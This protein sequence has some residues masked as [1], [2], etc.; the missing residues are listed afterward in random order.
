[1]MYILKNVICPIWK[2]KQKQCIGVLLLLFLFGL[3]HIDSF[4]QDRG[5]MEVVERDE[6]TGRAS[7]VNF[8]FTSQDIK[9]VLEWLSRETDLTIIATEDDIQNKKF[10][11]INLFDVT[12]DEVIEEVKTVLAQ[13]NLTLVRRNST[14]VV[15]TFDKAL[16]MTGPVKRITP[17]PEQVELTD[18]IQTYIIQLQNASA[19]D[20]VNAIKPLLNSKANVFADEGTNSLI[21]TDVSSNLKRIV[22]I[23]QFADAGE[24]FPLKITVIPLTSADAQAV[25][26]TLN[27]VFEDNREDTKPIRGDTGIDPEQ[28]KQAIEQGLGVELIEGMIR[29][30][31]DTNSNTLILKA[32]EDNLVI[33]K[34]IINHLD[35]APTLQTEI[36]T[37][38][39]Q[40]ASAEEVVTTLEEI[41]TG[42]NIQGGRR[43]FDREDILEMLT[44]R[45]D[46][47]SSGDLF[48]GIVGLVNLS[49]NDRLNIVV[50]SS[51]P[52]N[53]TIIEKLINEL[54]QKK[55][56]EEIKM[57]FLK[58][59]NAEDLSTNLQELFEGGSGG[60]D[61]DR[62][63]PWWDRGRSDETSEGG[64][65]VQGEVHIVFDVRLN[66]LIITTS[67]QN[68]PMIDELV[69]KLDVSMPEQEWG[70]RIFNLRYADAVNVAELLNSHYGGNQSNTGNRFD[71][72]WWIRSRQSPAQSAQTQ[73]SLAGNVTAQPYS[74]LNAVIVSTG[75][76]RNFELIEEFI[77]QIDV[78]TPPNQVEIT[79]TIRLEYATADAIAQI[80]SQVWQDQP[81]EDGFSFSRFVRDNFSDEPT[82]INS[83]F[84]KVTIFA[85]TDTNSLIVTTRRRYMEQVEALIKKL[86]FVRGQVWIDIKILEV[87][88]DEK[89]KLGIEATV[90]ERNLGGIEL[91][92]RNPLIGEAESQLGLSQEISGFN[93][94]LATKEYMAL[95]HTLLRENKVKTL[96][97]PSLLT[98]DSRPA[99]WSSGRRIP[100]LQSVDT[101]S[102]LGD[103]ATQ[104]LFNYDFID[105]PVG[106]NIS[107]TPY[108][109]RSKAGEDGKRTIGLDITN[110]S[111]SN[112]IEFTEFNAP[113]TDDNSLSVYIDVEDG[114]QLVVGGIIR[115]KQK[116]VENKVPILGDIPLLGRLFKSTETEV[117]D[118]EI[119]FI[120][121]PHIVDIQN[122]SDIEKLKQ[123]SDNWQ[124]N[125]RNGFEETK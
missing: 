122:P 10:S 48:Q 16:I 59:A 123:K 106:I 71:D 80:L 58:H 33:L 66:A 13:Y 109:A 17:D 105:P 15:T 95:L 78:P 98:R 118:T 18:E 34:E 11:L 43:S 27:R 96:S 86:D 120:I 89:T 125:G 3:I 65:G 57:Y 60:D 79:K 110:I 23:L 19:S 25:A 28:I 30:Y 56:L 94:S 119:V 73:G 50:V 35:N 46:E 9:N 68:F 29:V 92:S 55:T 41:I 64:F 44:Y 7:R 87:T 108:I 26:Q 39:L 53:Y 40:Y 90:N 88:L 69:E 99:T 12:I 74:N 72:W 5:Q 2:Q 100:Y 113:I 124:Q 117:Q 20:Q 38:R 47:V 21:I 85:E 121:T 115:K 83:L 77:G 6:E 54:D 31:A 82:D 62:Y 4:A 91:N 24:R 81:D 101:N 32:S 42:N 75:T 1:M 104:P 111:A 112:F 51:D 14:L 102:I 93:Y 107:L 97:T 63:R 49:R 45:R 67:A 76:K 8:N 37:Y 36:R 116:E 114:Q 103:T 84:G 52:R 61:D 22:S 70:T